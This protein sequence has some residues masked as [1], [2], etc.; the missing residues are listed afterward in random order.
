MG[1]DK[2]FGRAYIKSQLAAGQKL[3]RK[4]N[5]FVSVRDRDKRQ[6]IFIAKKLADLGFNIYASTGTA[7]VLDKSGIKV[8]VLPKIAEGRPNILDLMKDGKIQLVM[9]TPSGRIPR[10][11]EVKI[12]SHV[13]LYNIPYTTSIS[14]AQ[15]TVNGIE[16]LLKKD[17][18]VK[19]LQSYHKR[20]KR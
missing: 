15:A 7:D 14:A 10:Q 13:I 1:I 11:D 6:V 8:K 3:P 20:R 19:S 16:A 9:N 5:V 4:G 12:R 2:D 18:G 17:L